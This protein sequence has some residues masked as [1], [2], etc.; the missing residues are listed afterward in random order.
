M[1]AGSCAG[2]LPFEL[3]T[4][5]FASLR[6]LDRTSQWMARHATKLM[7]L[8]ILVGIGIPPLAATLRPFLAV[9]VWA[10]L[11][12]AMLQFDWEAVRGYLRRPLLMTLAVGWLVLATP[13][14]LSPAVTAIG[15]PIGIAMALILSAASAPIMSTPVICSIIGLDAALSL[16]VLLLTTLVV[17]FTLPI[18]AIELLDLEI[19]LTTH[20]L[21]WRLGTLIG[22]AMV[23]AVI[24]QRFLG[25]ARL[26]AA[27][28][29][30]DSCKLI[31]LLAMA[32][33]LM[34]GIGA[35][36]LDRPVY[37]L[38]IVALSFVANAGMQ[39]FAIAPFLAVGKRPTL[40]I[41]F[42]AGNRNMAIILA[43]IPVGIMP[44]LEL[45]LVLAQVPMYVLPSLLVPLYKRVFAL[46]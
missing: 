13:L 17:P 28:P 37:I 22:S 43:V 21:M 16:V 2:N 5:G 19:G 1:V 24:A 27:T 41:A 15:L 36:L 26:T 4:F 31:V 7:V 39:L 32:V 14:V 38:L 25:A 12:L 45:Y 10:I 34:D 35:L 44:D 33:A 46:E 9:I 8:S 20:E 40:T 11:F 30:I 3:H 6:M 18:I 42:S 29:T 23:L